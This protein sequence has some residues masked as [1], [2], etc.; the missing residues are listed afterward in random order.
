MIEIKKIDVKE[1]SKQLIVLSKL[2]AEED[3]TNGLIPNKLSDLKEPC[4]AAFDGDK[5]IGYIFGHFYTADK[6]IN[7]IEP[8]SKCFEVDEIYVLK[9]YRN[10]SIG[11]KLFKAM[12]EEVKK[13]AAYITLPT[14]TKDYQKI[15]KF[16]IEMMDMTFHSA[17][18]YKKTK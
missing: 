7:T 2:W 17:F 1:Y 9:Q 8:G 11:G 13:E 10:H 14:S 15:L 16:Y 3:I 5:V 4:I 12:E 6:K 18:L